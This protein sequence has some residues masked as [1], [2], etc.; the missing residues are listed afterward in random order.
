LYAR[1]LRLR[2]IQ[3]RPM[4]ALLLFEGSIAL[5]LLLVLAEIVTVWGIVAIPV[6]VAVMVKLNDLIAGLLSRPLAVA[7][8]RAPRLRAAVAVGRSPVPPPDGHGARRPEGPNRRTENAV[9]RPKLIARGVAAVR[10]SSRPPVAEPAG[11]L[12]DGPSGGPDKPGPGDQRGRGN[13]GRF[14]G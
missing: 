3:V 4:A 8:V 6:T 11:D 10:A 1:V 9:P 2:H 7:H 13:A 14:G 12:A 5:G